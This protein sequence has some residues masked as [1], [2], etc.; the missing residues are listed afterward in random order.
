MA[1]L[2]G[3]RLREEALRACQKPGAGDGLD[4]WTPDA[5]ASLLP[6]SDMES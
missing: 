1:V 5:C 4:T 3:V 2:G 6:W